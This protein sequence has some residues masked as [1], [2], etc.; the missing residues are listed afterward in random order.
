MSMSIAVYTT[1]FISNFAVPV[2]VSVSVPCSIFSM[3]KTAS[4][5]LVVVRWVAG[6]FVP[7]H[8]FGIHGVMMVVVVF[9]VVLV[10]ESMRVRNVRCERMTMACNG[11]SVGAS[12]SFPISLRGHAPASCFV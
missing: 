1:I 7:V 10:V 6:R 3:S 11:I 4:V 8:G 12:T 2:P 5:A 9:V